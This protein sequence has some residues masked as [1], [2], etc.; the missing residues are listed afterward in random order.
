MISNHYTGVG[1]EALSHDTTTLF[2]HVV[3]DIVAET[4]LTQTD[5]SNM[6]KKKGAV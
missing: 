4:M 3:P 2:K 5:R 6:V 1:N